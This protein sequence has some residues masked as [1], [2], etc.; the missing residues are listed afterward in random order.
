MNFEDGSSVVLY[1]ETGKKEEMHKR[2]VE[3]FHNLWT[4]AVGAKDYVKREWT[5]LIDYLS[6][7]QVKI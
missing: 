1:L 3:Q 2:L 7:F 5:D 4:K 6:E